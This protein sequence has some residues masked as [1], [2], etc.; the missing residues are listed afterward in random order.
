MS[1]IGL[2]TAAQKKHGYLSPDTLRALA[3]RRTSRSTG[4]SNSSRSTRT[5]APPRRRGSNSPCAAT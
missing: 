5:S 2:L 3:K 4:S 1:L